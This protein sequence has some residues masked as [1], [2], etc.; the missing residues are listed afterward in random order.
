MKKWIFLVIAIGLTHSV[1][2][3]KVIEKSVYFE[4]GGAA[5]GALYTLN[6]DIT[7]RKSA[8]SSYGLRIGIGG[9]SA[10]EDD[11]AFA[12]PVAFYSLIGEVEK[13]KFFEVGIGGTYFSGTYSDPIALMINGRFESYEINHIMGVA[14]LGYRYMPINKKFRFRVGLTPYF[15]RV[16]ARTDGILFSE[17]KDL[18]EKFIVSVI[19]HASFG[20][21]F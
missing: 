9:Y 1:V 6:A 16:D 17:S 21:A 5:L 12:L 18:G 8:A 19:P 15:G 13:G 3:Q 10:V 7:F 11:N 4:I 14:Y 20:I 2:S